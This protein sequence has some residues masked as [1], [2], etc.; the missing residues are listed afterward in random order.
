MYILQGNTASFG[1]HIMEYRTSLG[2]LRILVTTDKT[3][4]HLDFNGVRYLQSPTSWNNAS[5]R[6]NSVDEKVAFMAPQPTLN[7]IPLDA[8]RELFNLYTIDNLNIKIFA[9][10][11]FVSSQGIMSRRRSHSH[12]YR[13]VQVNTQST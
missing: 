12:K 9:S 6:V 2:Q 3:N 10:N 5:F 13:Q 8:I 1:C 7:A 11:V 4:Y